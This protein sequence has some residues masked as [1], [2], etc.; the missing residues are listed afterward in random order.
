M[1]AFVES[2]VDCRQTYSSLVGMF[3][4]FCSSVYESDSFLVSLVACKH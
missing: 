4:Q 3:Q 1:V 2:V